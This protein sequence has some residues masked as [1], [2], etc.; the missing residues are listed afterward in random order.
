MV[1]KF[2]FLQ[3]FR[4][5]ARAE[6]SFSDKLNLVVGP[7]GRGKTNLL[8]AIFLLSIGK[9]FRADK[10]DQM[11][12]L[13]ESVGRVG[14]R[15]WDDKG[16]SSEETRLEVVINSGGGV[17]QKRFSV[18]GVS[19]RRNVFAGMLRAVVF[20]PTDLEIVIGQPG[21]RRRFLDDVLEQVDSEYALAL[22]TYTKALRQR[23]ALL[24]RAQ[25]MGVRDEKNFSYWDE[26]LISNGK[27]VAQRREEF[28]SFINGKE[29]E[30]FGFEV[31]Y[32]KSEISEERLAKY[33]QAEM[34]AGVTLVGPHRDEVLI[35][36]H[37]LGINNHGVE[38]DSRPPI[39]VE[40]RLHG[41]DRGVAV[42]NFASRGE[43]RLVVLELRLAQIAYIEKRTGARPLLLLDDIFSELDEGHVRQVIQMLPGYQC[44]ITTTHPALGL[45]KEAGNVIELK[46]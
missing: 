29:R 20:L 8:E 40:G 32:D 38:L 46:K 33:R 3:N 37:E 30:F 25:E 44:V 42:K 26:L 2:L 21:V 39:A 17:W 9:S 1:L 14:G 19:R 27:V 31:V 35:L 43:Q 28:I 10:D 16:E 13:G 12:R 41:N 18:N 4:N 23:N 5:K 15:V 34:G 6:F 22:I 7:N 36:N 24:E 11:I 45:P